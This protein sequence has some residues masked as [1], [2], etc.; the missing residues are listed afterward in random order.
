[1]YYVAYKYRG[2][3]CEDDIEEDR[4]FATYEEALKHAYWLMTDD[5]T[6]RIYKKTE[7]G[8]K[9]VYSEND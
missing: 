4:P 2:W 8:Y 9:E 5:D 7:N 3:A 6:F 1:M